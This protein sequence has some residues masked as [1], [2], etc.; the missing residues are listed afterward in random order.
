MR[1]EFNEEKIAAAVRVIIEEL[2][3]DVQSEGLKETPERVARMYSRAIRSARPI[4]CA[5][6]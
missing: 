3:G 6:I 5:A 4:L 2:G 1:K